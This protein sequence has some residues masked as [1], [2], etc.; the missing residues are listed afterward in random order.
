MSARTKQMTERIKTICSH[1]P[2]GKKL[3]D[4]GCDHGFCAQYALSSGLF[5]TVYISDI[6]A[7]SLKKAETL[8]NRYV[9]EGR[10]VPVLA[11]GMKGLPK[12]CDCVLIAGLGGE[13]IM[14]I[15]SEGYLS[16]KFIFQPM[17]NAEK[18]RKYLIERGAKITADY[19]FGEGYF[20]D[21]IVGEREGGSAYTEEEILFGRDN[22]RTRS[23]SFLHKCE[24]EMSKL[25][26]YLERKDMSAESRAEVMN[27][28]KDWEKIHEVIRNL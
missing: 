23:P 21:L 3:A 10:C 25:R 28:K 11:D 2:Q 18:L 7:G 12:D 14:R 17:K 27:R 9:A 16:E 4:V 1:L 26:A 8:L 20:Y 6:S 22:L 13:E 24:D 5:E 15:L 19:T